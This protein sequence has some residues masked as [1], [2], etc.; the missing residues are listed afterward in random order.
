MPGPAADALP[1]RSARG[2]FPP[3]PFPSAPHA[4]SL[5]QQRLLGRKACRYGDGGA[6]HPDGD[7]RAARVA[8]GEPGAAGSTGCTGPKDTDGRVIPG[9]D[10]A[11]AIP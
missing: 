10:Q 7:N 1:A 8:E 4:E 2:G 5:P 9:R 11:P 3:R 6:T